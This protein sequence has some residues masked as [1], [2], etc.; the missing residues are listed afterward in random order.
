M[1][2]E[3]QAQAVTGCSDALWELIEQADLTHI[4]LRGGIGMLSAPTLE[5]CPGIEQVYSKDGVGVWEIT[6]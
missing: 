6:R 5:T 1:A 3:E 2:W 4:Y